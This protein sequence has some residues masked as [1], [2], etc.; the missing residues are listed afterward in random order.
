MDYYLNK[1]M[2]IVEKAWAPKTW[3]ITLPKMPD[4][5][6]GQYYLQAD[7]TFESMESFQSALKNGAAEVL[8][9][10][11]NFTTTQPLLM[12]GEQVGFGGSQ[13]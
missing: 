8:S 4:G 12:V 5:S 1:H 13:K 10:V 3:R 2:K 7:L 11:P 6:K 9:D